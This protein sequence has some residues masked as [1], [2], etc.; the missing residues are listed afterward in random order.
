MECPKCKH[1]QEATNKCESC[2]VYFSKLVPT[3]GTRPG[4]ARSTRTDRTRAE[5][6]EPKTGIT[7]F[8]VTAAVA[9]LLVFGYMRKGKE[10]PEPASNRPAASHQV[11]LIDDPRL[12]AGASHVTSPP[13]PARMEPSASAPT[14]TGNPL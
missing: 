6:P 14:T 9:G 7:P 2:G 12:S 1:Q 5:P 3:P 4:E 11:V 13:T 10:T 8:I